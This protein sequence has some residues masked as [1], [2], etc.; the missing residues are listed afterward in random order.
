MSAMDGGEDM[1]EKR[2]ENGAD[3]AK[4]KGQGKAGNDGNAGNDGGVDCATPTVYVH[5]SLWSNV[6]TNELKRVLMTHLS[7][8]Q[9]ICFFADGSGFRETGGAD[10]VKGTFLE[11]MGGGEEEGGGAGG[12]AVEDAAFRVVSNWLCAASASASS[13]S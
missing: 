1:E 5:C 12:G 2:T 6:E 7:R 13:V 9:S 10:G 3:N 11:E 4:E 8:G